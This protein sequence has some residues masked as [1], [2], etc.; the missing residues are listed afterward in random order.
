MYVEP[1]AK[2]SR[3]RRP[4]SF[5]EPIAPSNGEVPLPFRVCVCLEKR[6]GYES[7]EHASATA[8]NRILLGTAHIFLSNNWFYNICLHLWGGGRGPSV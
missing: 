7:S 4:G 3:R 5:N 6:H 2:S 8:T 1:I